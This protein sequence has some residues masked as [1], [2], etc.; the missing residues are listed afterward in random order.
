MTPT[1]TEQSLDPSRMPVLIGAGQITDK[2]PAETAGTPI[3]LMVEAARKAAADAGD[4]EILLH[5]GDT[6]TTPI[7]AKRQFMQYGSET[8]IAYITRRYDKPKAP[9]FI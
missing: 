9:E 8:T 5:K 4:E 1:Q 2:G 3:D 7:K 6:F